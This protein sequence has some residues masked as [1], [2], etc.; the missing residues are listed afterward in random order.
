[1]DI[2]SA[3]CSPRQVGGWVGWILYVCLSEHGAIYLMSCAPVL[4]CIHLIIPSLFCAVLWS[5]INI[6][7]AAC[8]IALA[9]A[10]GHGVYRESN[11]SLR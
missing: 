11:A 9:A 7:H 10:A 8:H 3:V 1:M 4:V 2:L 6:Y 5:T